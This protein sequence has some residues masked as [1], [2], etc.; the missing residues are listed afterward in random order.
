MDSS[1]KV[2]R[3]IDFADSIHFPPQVLWNYDEERL[4]T[5]HKADPQ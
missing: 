3:G 1:E 5:R 2:R 4:F